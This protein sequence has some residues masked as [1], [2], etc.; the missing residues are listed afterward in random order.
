M[1]LW[2]ERT[3]RRG[4]GVEGCVVWM[5]EE[6]EGEELVWKAL[7]L[8]EWRELEGQEAMWVRSVVS[9]WVGEEEEWEED[10]LYRLGGT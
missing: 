3:R 1:V 8:C 5:S 4:S 7:W 10:W 9:M 2:V 6:L